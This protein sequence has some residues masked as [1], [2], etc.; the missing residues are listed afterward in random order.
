MA[1]KE[2]V[3][4]CE[5]CKDVYLFRD[6]RDRAFAELQAVTTDRQ[7]ERER[8][9]IAEAQLDAAENAIRYLTAAIHVLTKEQN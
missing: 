8:A 1:K 9:R 5:S 2:R 4:S 7:R 6:E 3:T